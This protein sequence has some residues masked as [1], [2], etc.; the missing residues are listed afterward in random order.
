MRLFFLFSF[1]FPIYIFSQL[2]I[3]VTIRDTK[4]GFLANTTTYIS[5]EG[6]KKQSLPTNASGL[7]SYEVTEPGNY[8]F[9]YASDQKGFDFEMIEGRRGTMNR[10]LTYDPEGVFAKPPKADRKG[11]QFIVEE[12]KIASFSPATGK[13]GYEIILKNLKGIPA[14]NIPVVMVDITAK[15]KYSAKTDSRGMAKFLIPSGKKYEIDVDGIEALD[16]VTVPAV[17]YGV[18]TSEIPYEA[19]KLAERIVGDTIYQS[20]IKQ[21]DGATTHAYAEINL[22]DFNSV[23]LA[24]EKVYLN[25][26]YSNRVYAGTTDENGKVTF[27]LKNGTDYVMNLTLE[28]DVRLIKLDETRGF[29]TMGMTHMYRGTE[30]IRSM[31]SSRKRDDKGF[32]QNFEATPIEKIDGKGVETISNSNG[33]QLK[34]EENGKVPPVTIVNG[35]AYFSEGFYSKNFYAY[36]IATKNVTWAVRLGESGA[37]AAVYSDGVL[38]INTYSCT[39]YALDMKTGKL[40]WSKYLANTLYSNPSISNGNVLVVYDNEFEISKNNK[41]VLANFDLK[42]GAIK[43]QKYLSDDAIACPV[44]D[45]EKVHVASMNGAYKVFDVLTGDMKTEASIQ[46]LSSPTIANEEIFI[47]RNEGGSEV[48]SMYDKKSFKKLKD[49]KIADST[50]L[51]D[52][53]CFER[54]HYQGTRSVAYKGHNY[55]ISGSE[56]TCVNPVSEKI[57]WKQTIGLNGNL[58]VV[59]AANNQVFVQT[60]K[61]QILFFE[62]ETGKQVNVISTNCSLYSQP[63]FAAKKLFYS[64]DKGT[65]F[66]QNISLGIEYPQWNGNCHHNLSYED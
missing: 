50:S 37:G 3:A 16:I 24:N 60:D 5:V 49:I 13:C 26:Q 27:M 63:T 11:I 2:N 6:I 29:K 30:N 61:N 52:T 8:T 57:I 31:L 41:Y 44:I 66:I 48:L 10:T 21:T 39:L 40:L 43:W 15:T 22:V 45:G 65:V 25:D 64:D 18:F 58:R 19:P 12:Q 28:Q 23:G 51:I 55:L 46:A 35:V 9:Y 33:L 7:V 56:L 42:T 34:M 32:I 47:T 59:M 4:G 17:K 20:N 38:L 1:L 62:A 53:K 36:N 54:M 14:T